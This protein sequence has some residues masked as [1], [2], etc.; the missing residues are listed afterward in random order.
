[1]IIAEAEGGDDAVTAI[2]AIRDEYELPHYGGGTDEEIMDPILEERRRTL[3]LDG[4]AIGDHLRYGIP[5][6]TG[7]NQK[8]VRYGDLTCLP[9]PP[10]ELSGR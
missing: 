2:N 8:G 1:L 9:L 10:S 5:F 4:H 3:F 6:A 7:L